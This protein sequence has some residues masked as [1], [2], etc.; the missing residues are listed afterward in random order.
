MNL[1]YEVFV[2]NLLNKS[3]VSAKEEKAEKKRLC[4][5][6]NSVLSAKCVKDVEK[7]SDADLFRVTD[8]IDSLC[9]QGGEN[10]QKKNNLLS[11]ISKAPAYV[12]DRIL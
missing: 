4:K 10:E 11:D 9:G 8:H 3:T 12:S 1:N 6:L 5:L 2:K 7:I